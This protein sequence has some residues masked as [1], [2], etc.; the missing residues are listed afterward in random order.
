VSGVKMS[1][2][3]VRRQTWHVGSAVQEELATRGW[4][5]RRLSRESGLSVEDIAAVLAGEI[6]TREAARGLARAFRTE[7]DLYLSADREVREFA[8]QKYGRCGH[9]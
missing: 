2:R 3:A 5:A 7:P 9:W 6:V 4:S 1:L 8:I